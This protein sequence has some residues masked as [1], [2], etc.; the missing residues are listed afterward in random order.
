[1]ASLDSSRDAGFFSSDA[2]S[3]WQARRLRYNLAL[4]LAAWA[5]YFL[6]VGESWAFGRPVWRDA[7]GALGMTLFLGTIWLVVMGIANVCFLLGPAVEAWTKPADVDAY[8]RTTWNL[9]FRGSLAVPFIFPALQL[10][11]LITHFG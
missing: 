11:T 9:G 4:A 6:M 3:W 1:M 10:A 5:A 7:G 2:W 8:R